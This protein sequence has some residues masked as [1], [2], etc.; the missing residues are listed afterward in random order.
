MIREPDSDLLSLPEGF[1]RITWE[2]GTAEL[3][4][5]VMTVETFEALRAGQT[6]VRGIR[7]KICQK[8]KMSVKPSTGRWTETASD[9]FVNE[10]AW[11]LEKMAESGMI[12]KV[13]QRTHETSLLLDA[14]ERLSGVVDFFRRNEPFE[15][16]PGAYKKAPAGESPASSTGLLRNDTQR[17]HPPKS[18]SRV[19]SP[20]ALIASALAA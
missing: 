13:N 1:R 18:R 4:K 2:N 7:A 16:R 12:R 8:R 10:H 17:T 15:W 9:R 19:T 5:S 6:N 20:A 3:Q 11:V 14:E